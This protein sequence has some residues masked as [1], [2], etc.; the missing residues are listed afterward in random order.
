[1]QDE[2]RFCKDIG[3]FAVDRP[4]ASCV[5]RSEFCR[6]H[7]YNGKL[8][9]IYKGMK[10]KD[11]RNAD[12]WETLTGQG[13]ADILKGKR[14]QTKRFRF[15]TR[16]E[17]L[18]TM[19]DVDRVVEICKSNPNTLFWLPTRG[20]RNADL[21]P[22]IEQKLSKIRNLRLMASIDPSNTE[23]EIA[24]LVA[25]GWSTMFFGNDDH[26]PIADSV[27][28]PKTWAKKHGHCAKCTGG[29]FSPKQ[30]HV[31]LKMH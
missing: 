8:Y 14:H 21:R 3:M 17:A 19:D 27:K 29:C 28:C 4:M 24:G 12:F 10:G 1:M 20:W 15:M 30:R 18:A 16:G 7:C 13:L 31:W 26:A 11:C 5:H 6:K 2:T 22:V 25:G 9:K 23:S